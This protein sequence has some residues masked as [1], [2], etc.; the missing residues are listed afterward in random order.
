MG[1][2]GISVPLLA[3]AALCPRGVHS[4]ASADRLRMQGGGG[5][6][7]G[8]Q[9]QTWPGRRPGL[10]WSLAPHQNHHRLSCTVRQGKPQH[11]AHWQRRMPQNALPLALNYPMHPYLRSHTSDLAPPKIS[12]VNIPGRSTY[13]WSLKRV[14]RLI[15]RAGVLFVEHT[16][17]D[18]GRC[19]GAC[20]HRH[21][22]APTPL[23]HT[24]AHA[25]PYASPHTA[26][27]PTLHHAP[28]YTKSPSN[29]EHPDSCSQKK[30][31]AALPGTVQ[32]PP[33]HSPP[34]KKPQPPI[35]HRT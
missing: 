32:H 23:H 29:L 1:E 11:Q 17:L 9:P 12:A 15:G 10:A 27:N 24:A 18:G 8:S 19:A 5:G 6:D 14:L 3:I 35:G 22:T 13:G 20:M 30:L 34:N 16:I 25:E 26:R 33:V 21:P 4:P 28:H 31:L 7:R 2:S